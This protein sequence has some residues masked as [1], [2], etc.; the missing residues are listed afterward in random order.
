MAA[1]KDFGVILLGFAAVIAAYSY[2]QAT[3]AS[4][5]AAIDKASDEVHDY[6]LIQLGEFRQDQY[7]LDKKTGR[8]WTNGCVGRID[9]AN[10]DGDT[11]WTEK[12][13]VGLNGYTQEDLARYINYYNKSVA[14]SKL[15]DSK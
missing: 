8:T 10:C 12:L 2:Y 14:E 7:L 9:G 15:E 11:L 3:A 13:V 6:Q 1:T 5:K 4:I